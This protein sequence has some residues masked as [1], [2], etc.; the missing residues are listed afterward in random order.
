MIAQIAMKMMEYFDGDV[1]RINHAMKV[2]SFAKIVGQSEGL[3]GD[4]LFVLEAAALLHDIG[5]KECEKKY[6]NCNGTYQEA[7]GPPVARKILKQFGIEKCIIDRICYLI[8]HHHS[9]DRID[10]IEFQ[11]LVEADFIVNIFE[12]NIAPA[13][14]ESINRKFVKT[15]TSKKLFESMYHVRM[16]VK[17]A[18]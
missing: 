16:Q 17:Q 11:I 9:Y 1:K 10:D 8:G 15:T 4:Y 6:G 12:D 2:Y 7:E 14:I 5:I 18:I 3:S 13:S